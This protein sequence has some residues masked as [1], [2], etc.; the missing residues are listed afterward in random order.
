MEHGFHHLTVD[1]M[2]KPAS[3]RGTQ[4][5]QVFDPLGLAAIVIMII[6]THGDFPA[7]CSTPPAIDFIIRRRIGAGGDPVDGQPCTFRKIQCIGDQHLMITAFEFR[8]YN[9]GD[10][11]PDIHDARTGRAVPGCAGGWVGSRT[12]WLR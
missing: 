8:Y 6:M 9:R 1:V 11:L 5:R 2:V 12:I 3:G 7:A 4:E 10:R